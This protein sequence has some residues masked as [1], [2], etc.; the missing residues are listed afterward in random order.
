[1]ADR[2]GDNLISD[3][4]TELTVELAEL[5]AENKHVRIERI[6]SAGHAH[7]DGFW[8]DQEERKRRTSANASISCCSSRARNSSIA[9]FEWPM[10]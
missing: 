5:L 2:L 6:V 1:M 4:P 9:W 10:V 3:L 8:Y 7:L